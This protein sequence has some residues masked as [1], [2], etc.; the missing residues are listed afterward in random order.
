[1]EPKKPEDES[2]EEVAPSEVWER[3]RPEQRARIVHL[4]ARIVSKH[5]NAGPESSSLTK[6]GSNSQGDCEEKPK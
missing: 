4:L 5:I 2:E 1:M 6:L 3:L